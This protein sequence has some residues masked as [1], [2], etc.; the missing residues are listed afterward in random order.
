MLPLFQYASGRPISIQQIRHYIQIYDSFPTIGLNNEYI[1]QFALGMCTYQVSGYVEILSSKEGNREGGRYLIKNAASHMR[2][3][4]GAISD[5]MFGNLI[6]DGYF[7]AQ[8]YEE[9]I[10]LA[11]IIIG[12]SKKLRLDPTA[13]LSGVYRMKAEM[14]LALVLQNPNENRQHRLL[15]ASNSLKFAFEYL[16]FADNP[17]QEV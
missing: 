17:Y 9:G 4:M 13:G 15:E 6:L 10:A 14:L 16:E 12:K 1:L 5:V 2:E 11:E 8:M 7:V 3:S